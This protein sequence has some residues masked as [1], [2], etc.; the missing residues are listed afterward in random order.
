MIWTDSPCYTT[1]WNDSNSYL[2]ALRSPEIEFILAQHPWLES[3]CY[4]A[5][6]ILPV[7][8]KFELED[9]D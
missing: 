5:D 7:T 6:L 8:T 1:C 4:F 2:K 9:I 3:D